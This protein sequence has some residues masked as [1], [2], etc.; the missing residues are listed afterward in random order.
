MSLSLYKISDNSYGYKIS[1]NNTVIDQPFK[2]DADGF[3]PM[4]EAEAREIGQA[5]YDELMKTLPLP[6]EVPK[7]IIQT[8]EPIIIKAPINSSVLVDDAEY[9]LEDGIL[10]YSNENVGVYEL[11]F[12]LNK[13]NKTSV[14]IEV[15]K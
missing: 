12:S 2:P 7:T 3:T 11:E 14:S 13:S 4:T 9:L 8:G 15:I 10:E 5:I 1:I 6:I